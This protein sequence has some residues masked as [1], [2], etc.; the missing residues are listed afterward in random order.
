M[1]RENRAKKPMASRFFFFFC[2]VTLVHCPVAFWKFTWSYSIMA[3]THLGVCGLGIFMSCLSL[4]VFLFWQRSG[5]HKLTLYQ[6]LVSVRTHRIWQSLTKPLYWHM[7]TSKHI[8][9]CVHIIYTYN[10]IYIYIFEKCNPVVFWCHWN[11]QHFRC[12]FQDVFFT[13]QPASRSIQNLLSKKVKQKRKV[14]EEE[15]KSSSS[16]CFRLFNFSGTS[17]TASSWFFKNAWVGDPKKNI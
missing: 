4:A 9:V 11:F 12:N 1:I 17:L 15:Q 5:Y 13:N 6:T 2:H 14:N 10:Y 7:Q 8:A 16:S 3:K